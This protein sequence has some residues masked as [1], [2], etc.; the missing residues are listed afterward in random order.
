[1]PPSLETRIL[2]RGLLVPTLMHLFKQ[3][4]AGGLRGDDAHVPAFTLPPEARADWGQGA[5][6]LSALVDAAHGLTHIPP[7]ARLGGV[8]LGVEDSTR[9]RYA[10][11]AYSRI[12]PHHVAVVLRPG[13]TLDLDFD[14][15]ESFV[16]AGRSIREYSARLLRGPGELVKRSGDGARWNLRVAWSPA[17]PGGGLR[18]DVVLLVSDGSYDSAPA[19]VSIKHVQPFE[20]KLL[21]EHGRAAVPASEGSKAK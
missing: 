11:A 15:S 6:R 2:R 19:Y 8:T 18:T 16:D 21:G 3:H 14:L 9:P 1:M 10:R 4:Y 20:R 12:G 13:E 5:E 17:L 7:V